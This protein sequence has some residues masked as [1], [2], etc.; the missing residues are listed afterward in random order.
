MQGPAGYRLQFLPLNSR[1]VKSDCPL[2]I[3]GRAKMAAV[4]N[5]SERR[6]ARTLLTSFQMSNLAG[7]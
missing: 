2:P 4:D 3:T 5:A 7:Y 1:I 6:T